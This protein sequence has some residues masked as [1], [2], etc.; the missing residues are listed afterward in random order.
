MMQ[1]RYQIATLIGDSSWA[2][3][4]A[5]DKMIGK[6]ANIAKFIEQLDAAARPIAEREF[7]MLQAEKRKTNPG[8]TEIAGYESFRYSE[9]VRRSQYDFDS[10][11]A[12]PYFPYN[13]VKRGVLDTAAALFHISFKQ[14]FNAPAWDPSVETWDVIQNGKMI[15]QFYLDMH[16]RPGK[17]R[18]MAVILD[19]VRGKQLPEAILEV[20]FSRADYH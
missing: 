18:Q 7:T 9:L 14:E 2:D 4:S 3:Y 17:C 12:R 11:S 10:Q 19:G 15:G 16:P 20:Q 8:A 5:A 1:T 6:G 13:Q